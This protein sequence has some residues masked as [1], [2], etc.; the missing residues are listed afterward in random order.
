MSSAIRQTGRI[1][2]A[3]KKEIAIEA[4]KDAIRSLKEE[5]EEELERAAAEAG[6]ESNGDAPKPPKI[7]IR[8][9]QRGSVMLTMTGPLAEMFEF[10][11]GVY[12]NGNDSTEG[13]EIGSYGK[14]Q[15]VNEYWYYGHDNGKN[16]YAKGIPAVHL[17]E[18]IR[19]DAIEK[20]KDFEKIAKLMFSKIKV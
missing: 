14:G 3:V 5:Y 6:M 10:G 7:G 1:K 4:A 8:E 16:L 9:T 18:R 11:A 15:G 17:S 2:D 13:H 20:R 19:Y 12:F